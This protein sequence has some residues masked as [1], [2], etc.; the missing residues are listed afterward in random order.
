[1][2]LSGVVHLV[3][4]IVRGGTW[5]GPLSWRKPAVFGFSFAVTDIAVAWIL[6]YLPKRRSV[7]WLLAGS[8]AVFSVAEVF[9]ISMQKWRGVASHF[10][11]STP[12]DATVFSLMG[13][14]VAAIA[15]NIVILT[16]WSFRSRLAS[17]SM[18]WAIRG[19]LVLL[20]V[21]QGLGGAIIA[22]GTS[23]QGQGQQTALNV[24]GPHGAMK[25]PHAVA[26][27]ALQVLPLL[28]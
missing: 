19:G 2:F 5:F 28:A 18:A 26:L 12:F 7:G 4:L 10:N 6:G 22:N 1:M 9:L 17:R 27:H 16:V 11:N 14:F 8:L 13:V 15:A 20:I 25:V 23:R 3:I 24:F 21:G